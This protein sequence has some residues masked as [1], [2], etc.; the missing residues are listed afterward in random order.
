MIKNLVKVGIERTY[1]NVIK[2]M[3][4]KPTANM[5]FNGEKLK[6]FPLKHGRR[7]GYQFSPFYSTQ[8]W[9][10]YP[11]KA[12]QKKKRKRKKEI[13][14]IPIGREKVKFVTICR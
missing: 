3:Y 5:I 8:N 10:S 9:K 12:D 13:K 1:I 14:R 2:A 7:Q 4:D 11:Q 6:V